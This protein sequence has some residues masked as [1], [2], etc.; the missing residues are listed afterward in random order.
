MK[1]PNGKIVILDQAPL[2]GQSFS[3]GQAFFSRDGDLHASAIGGFC[4]NETKL[5][6]QVPVVMFDEVKQLLISSDAHSRLVEVVEKLNLVKSQRDAVRR[7][8]RSKL[9]YASRVR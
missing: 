3:V 5:M 9:H 6:K 4:P 8:K 1:M 2:A 7:F